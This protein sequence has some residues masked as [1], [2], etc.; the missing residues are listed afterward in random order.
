MCRLHL[1]GPVLVVVSA[2]M[3]E[4]DSARNTSRSNYGVSLHDSQISLADPAVWQ[5]LLI[6]PIAPF[7]GG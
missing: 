6:W 4:R 7:S 1:G 2:M 3:R 5:H